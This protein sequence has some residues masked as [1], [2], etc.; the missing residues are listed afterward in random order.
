MK[1]MVVIVKEV[2]IKTTVVE[3][4]DNVEDV[5]EYCWE[6]ITENYNEL[7]WEVEDCDTDVIRIEEYDE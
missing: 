6:E 2:V 1:S 3:V 4:P 5:Q 7:E